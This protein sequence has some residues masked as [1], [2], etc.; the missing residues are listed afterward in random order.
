MCIK[1]DLG[2]KLEILPVVF[3][4]GT[5]DAS[6][7]PFRLFR[8]RTKSWEDGYARTHQRLLSQKNA[9]CEG[10][11]IP[12][13]KVLKHLRSLNNLQAV[14]FHL[15]AL[16]FHVPNQAFRGS[17]S[18]YIPRVLAEI[19]ERI[20]IGWF[21]TTLRTP[22]GER[23]LFTSREW[24]YENWSLFLQHC[25]RWAAGARTAS[26]QLSRGEAICEWQSLLGKQFF[27]A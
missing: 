5:S 12:M 7:E 4:Q 15:E 18:T 14:S 8:P 17:P 21:L 6:V 9:G 24:S 23:D 1:V 27:A 10:N 26:R 16:L 19:G 2:I 13:I 20:D 3:A 11:F 25:R 22:C